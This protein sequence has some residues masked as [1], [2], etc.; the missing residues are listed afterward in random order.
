MP[1]SSML[2]IG[3]CFEV[4]SQSTLLDI[5]SLDQELVKKQ[6]ICLC[7]QAGTWRVRSNRHRG[8]AG[9]MEEA[10]IIFG[11]THRT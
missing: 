9:K 3:G 6:C 10:T 8:S 4:I 1:I 2:A 5:L 7:F 11:Q